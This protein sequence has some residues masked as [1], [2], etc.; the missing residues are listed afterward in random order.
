MTSGCIGQVYFCIFSCSL[1]R[2]VGRR[3]DRRRVLAVAIE[4][5]RPYLCG[6]TTAQVRSRLWLQYVFAF[7]LVVGQ[8]PRLPGGRRRQ[9]A[10]VALQTS[11]RLRLLYATKGGA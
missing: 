8:A 1:A 7:G 9:P 2:A 3:G 6:D 10:A 4:V 11:T 5:N